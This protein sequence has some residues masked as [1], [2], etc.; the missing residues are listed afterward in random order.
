MPGGGTQYERMPRHRELPFIAQ[1]LAVLSEHCGD[2]QT[3]LILSEAEDRLAKL[4]TD[5][6]VARRP[7][8]QCSGPGATED[9]LWTLLWVELAQP[10]RLAVTADDFRDVSVLVEVR[11][12]FGAVLLVDHL[13]PESVE[14]AC[15]EPEQAG[16]TLGEV[17][18]RP[19]E[20]RLLR[21]CS[22]GYA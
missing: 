16:I 2:E 3:D 8:A 21:R 9:E 19:H 17:S 10:R 7:V 18:L 15:R 12:L 4:E 6:L 13:V 14:P 22:T 11:K 5:P 20:A 1:T